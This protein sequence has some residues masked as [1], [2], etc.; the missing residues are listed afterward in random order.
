[1]MTQNG[2]EGLVDGPYHGWLGYHSLAEQGFKIKNFKRYIKKNAPLKFT[3]PKVI[4][5]EV[6]RSCIYFILFIG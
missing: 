5:A 1:M 2:N 3:D 4:P 6:N